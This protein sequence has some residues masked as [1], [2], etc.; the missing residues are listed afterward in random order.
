MKMYE[1]TTDTGEGTYIGS[2]DVIFGL[3]GHLESKG[4]TCTVTELTEEQM[5]LADELPF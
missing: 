3:K 4:W 2:W 1:L 5:K